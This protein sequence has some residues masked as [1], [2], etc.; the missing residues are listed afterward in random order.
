[1]QS[2]FTLHRILSIRFE[3]VFIQI[4]P[5]HFNVEWTGPIFGNATKY[6]STLVSGSTPCKPN[7]GQYTRARLRLKVHVHMP[8]HP[9]PSSV[10]HS[11]HAAV[12]D[13]I[14]HAATAPYPSLLQGHRRPPNHVSLRSGC[15]PRRGTRLHHCAGVSPARRRKKS[16]PA[17][18]GA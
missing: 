5:C 17:L 16:Q 18:G 14:G 1:M 6:T 3:D 13:G 9:A 7:T 8:A 10:S 4:L 11:V 15:R 2:D 12:C